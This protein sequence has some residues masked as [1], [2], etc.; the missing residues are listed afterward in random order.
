MERFGIDQRFSLPYKP[1]SQGQ[2]E[3]VNGTLKRAIYAH[4]AEHTTKNFTDALQF[5]VYSYNSHTHNTIK[6]SPFQSHRGRDTKI[7]MLLSTLVHSRL[8]KKGEEMIDDSMKSNNPTVDKSL[9]VGD[10]V[11]VMSMSLKSIRKLSTIQK[12]S[13]TITNWSIKLYLITEVGVEDIQEKYKIDIS[14][15]DENRWYSRSEL[16]LVDIENL[17]EKIGID[18]N[19]ED[20]NFGLKYDRE[21]HLRNLALTRS[22]RAEANKG[23]DEIDAEAEVEVKRGG[24]RVRRLADRG[25]YLS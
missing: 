3:R 20:L 7:S 15:K 25:P 12:N 18:E 9:V 14:G 24:K 4:M 8:V 21:G 5:L 1:T 22:E 11:R 16:M 19:K 6:V 10:S 23:I 13:R 2:V 17:V